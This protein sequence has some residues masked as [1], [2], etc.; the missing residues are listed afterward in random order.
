M[1]KE[2]SNYLD[3]YRLGEM[4]RREFM[5]AMAAAGIS[6]TSA[7]ALLATEAMA[8]TPK[9][10]GHLRLGWHDGT[11]SDTLD[12]LKAFSTQAQLL[13]HTVLS[14][15]TE[16]TP[17]GELEPLLAESYEPNAQATEWTFDLRRGVEFHNGKTVDADDVMVSIERHRGSKS[18]SAMLAVVEQITEMR[19]DG[20]YRVIFTLREGNADFP[21]L[22]SSPSL[23]ILQVKDD[24]L[25]IG[26][27]SG[28]Y[29]MERFDPG[30]VCE[31]KRYPN[32][33]KDDGAF[34]DSAEVI[35]LSDPTAR[36][37]ALINGSVDIIAFV[38][39]KM[40]G[41]LAQEEGI[42]VLDVRGALHYTYPM[43]LDLEPF[44]DNNDLRLAL[45][46]AFDREDVLER[47]LRGRGALGND[48][49]VSPAMRYHASEIPQRPYDPEKAK[50]HLKK[51]GME[52]F[53]HQLTGSEG[54]YPG[55]MDMILLYKEHAAKA[56]IEIIPRNMP[57]DGYYSEVWRQHPW[58][59]SWSSGRPT[60]DWIFSLF[61]GAG[62]SWN[63]TYWEH[64]RF[65]ML[66]K[67]ARAELDESKRREMYV[68]MQQIC[69]DEGGSV[70]PLF[71]SHISGHSSKVAHPEK[72]A[73]NFEMD[74]LKVLERWWFA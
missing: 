22:L 38:P 2:T 53:K 58:S 57:A 9:R 8:A 51:A 18:I 14:Q 45:K 48:H 5:A 17:A 35:V 13:N 64:A 68:E 25:V 37:N 70:I 24:E 29:S 42:E 32:Y 69:R 12:P 26:G 66:L 71:A 49:P 16:V 72:V 67:A 65:N 30:V 52:G 27:G 3:K 19:K 62:S 23:S 7:S 61:Y 4:S 60:E 40:A 46:Y 1:S 41:L 56:G 11:P 15:L 10:G 59:A 39:P 6:A 36:Q 44:K 21:F 20:N 31:L 63:E 28:G 43:R 33:F 47:I 73:G 74:G 34:F 50:F 54:F 55:C